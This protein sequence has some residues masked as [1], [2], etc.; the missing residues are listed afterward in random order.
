MKLIAILFLFFSLFFSGTSYASCANSLHEVFVN[1]TCT[2][3]ETYKSKALTSNPVLF[4]SI[5][6]D[7]PFNRPSY[8]YRVAR[9]VAR[10][11]E[12]VIAV[13][14][15]RPG[16]TDDFGRMS[17]GVRGEGVGDNYDNKRV[18]Q[19][20]NVI[21]KLK[22]VHGAENVVVAGHS[23]GA[24][25]TAK[26][27]ALRPSL[28]NEAFI[29]SCPCDINSWRNDMYQRDRYEL[30]KGDLLVESPLSLVSRIPGGVKITVVTGKND[31]IVKPYISE[32]YYSALL[33][34][35]KQ[36]GFFS[37]DGGHEIFQNKVV[38][39]ALLKSVSSYKQKNAADP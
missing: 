24:A 34:I 25:I 11:S 20:A 31:E 22:L 1:D 29:V 8:H 36:A 6:G 37:V 9:E 13:G 10:R 26:I 30:F 16:Y 2:K 32:A 19:V 17:D 4:V 38:I 33:K 15:L 35:Q 3:V 12:N 7:A 28:L 39:D 23:G 21:A 14:I 18:R 27:L 5:H